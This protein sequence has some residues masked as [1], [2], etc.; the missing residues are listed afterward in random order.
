MALAMLPIPLFFLSFF[1]HLS[2]TSHRLI[3]VVIAGVALL[4][5]IR[6]FSERKNPLLAWVM[7]SFSHLWVLLAI[8]FNDRFYIWDAT[9]YLSGVIVSG[10]AG[11]IILYTLSKKETFD[12][13]NFYGL[14]L[15]QKNTAFWYLICSLGLM[16]FP[17]TTTFLGEDLLFTH[18]EENQF[19]LAALISFTFILTGISLMRIYARVFLGPTKGTETPMARRSS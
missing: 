19:L 11:Y 18:I 1:I 12:L 17:V 7:L 9:L 16:G 15:R 8:T 13:N 10:I 2:E 6:S 4:L 14:A 5:V 3:S